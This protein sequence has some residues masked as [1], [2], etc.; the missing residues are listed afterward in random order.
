MKLLAEDSDENSHGKDNPEAGNRE[1][2]MV[3]HLPPSDRP[4]LN[5]GLRRPRYCPCGLP[6]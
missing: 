6:P 3:K 4:G 1:M 5:W 2:K